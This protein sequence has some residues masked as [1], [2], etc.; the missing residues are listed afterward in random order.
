[1]RY[2]SELNWTIIEVILLIFVFVVGF[3]ITYLLLPYIIK[4]M[5]RKGYVGIDIHKNSK[6]KVAE[7]G[8][9]GIVIGFTISSLFLMLFF[10]SFS[11][12]IIIFLLTV[13]LAGVIGYVD[14][15]IRLRSRYKILLLI[16]SG[17]IFFFA[18]NVGFISISS[19]TIPFL[20]QTRLTIIYPFVIPIIFAIFPNTVNM[21]EG[22][23]G[24]GSGTCLIAVFFLLISGIIWDSAE[25][26]IFSVPVIAVLIAFFIYNKFPAKIFPGDVGTLSMGAM[27]A[28]I[29]LFGS[30]EIAAFCAMLIHI[31]NS[32]YVI[33]S[34]RGFIESGDIKAGKEDIILLKNDQIKASDQ[35]D[36]VL[37]LPRLI[38]AKGPL[39]EPE[40]VKNFYAISV[41]CGFFSIISILFMQ[42]TS[43]NF[44]FYG[45]FLTFIVLLIPTI[46][47][48]YKFPR[49]RGIILL[50]VILLFI[51]MFLLMLI[52]AYIMP[53]PLEDLDLKFVK[54]PINLI[55]SILLII[56]V[57]LIWYLITIKYFW[58][59]INKMKNRL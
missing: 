42:F 9:L 11:N 37:T 32:F 14:D 28:G 21:L 29:I 7:S 4:L 17:S 51:I 16:F 39:K 15:R 8:G 33:Y 3:L 2:L 25:A 24:E 30:L 59:E 5:Q 1:M 31:F 49:I 52:E 45:L 47:I 43:G 55:I 50:M 22:Y 44:E 38:L 12:E 54:I 27:I 57:L 53:L 20:D 13:I 34:V 10:P 36:A 41:I 6:P 58:W 26:I 40:L 46:I 23:N 35:K 56:P 19:P 48:L 18:I